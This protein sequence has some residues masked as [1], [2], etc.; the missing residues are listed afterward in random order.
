MLVSRSE[1]KLKKVE[2]EIH[3]LGMGVETK[4]IVADF[5]TEKSPQFYEGIME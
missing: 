2:S 4:I 5:C 3:K 1:T